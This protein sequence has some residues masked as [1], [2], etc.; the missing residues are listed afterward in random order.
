M[1]HFYTVLVDLEYLCTS[2]Q[3][4]FLSQCW[5][6]TIT[7]K[8]STRPITIWVYPFSLQEA[9]KRP[10]KWKAT[11]GSILIEVQHS[12]HIQ[13][14]PSCRLLEMPVVGS[15]EACRTKGNTFLS[16]LTLKVKVFNLPT[17][18][19]EDFLHNKPHCLTIFVFIYLIS[20][21]NMQIDLF[22]LFRWVESQEI[23]KWNQI[24][25]VLC[26]LI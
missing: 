4:A 16:S 13:W 24:I 17:N 20:D 2:L 15:Y 12:C 22:F 19:T 6:N 9:N 14:K 10:Y 5:G 23:K 26:H 11:S 7:N 21:Y 3:R 18:L 8:H 1:S 25:H